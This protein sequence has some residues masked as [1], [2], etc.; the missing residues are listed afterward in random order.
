MF[1][2]VIPST[3]GHLIHIVHSVPG[4]MLSFLDRLSHLILTKKS[5]K[6]SVTDLGAVIPA[7]PRYTTRIFIHTELQVAVT[8]QLEGTWTVKAITFSAVNYCQEAVGVM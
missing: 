5:Y 7:E 3:K 4:L 8:N 1:D 6:G 2:F